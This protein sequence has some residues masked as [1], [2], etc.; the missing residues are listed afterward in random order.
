MVFLFCGLTSVWF[1]NCIKKLK[2]IQ[3]RHTCTYTCT[4]TSNNLKVCDL[5]RYVV[6]VSSSYVVIVVE[7][8]GT[9]GVKIT[10]EYQN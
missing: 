10:V 5:F 7:V 9:Q 1:Y 2:F 8:S 3:Y 4:Y 6:H